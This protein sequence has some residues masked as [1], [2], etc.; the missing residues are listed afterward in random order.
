MPPLES[1]PRRSTVPDRRLGSAD[2]PRITLLEVVEVANDLLH[3]GAMRGRELAPEPPLDPAEGGGPEGNPSRDEE[4]APHR[5]GQ[6]QSRGP[7]DHQ[8]GADLRR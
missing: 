3:S 4:G 6:E 7:D 8:Q 1:P 5:A 2:G